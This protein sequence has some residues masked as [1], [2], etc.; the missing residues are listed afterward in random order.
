MN[1]TI[2]EVAKRARVS[3]ATVSRVLNN[4]G[5]VDENT[6]R[7][8]QEAARELRYVPNAVGRSLSTRRT[9]AIGLLLPDLYG[10]FFSEVIRGADQTAQQHRLHIVVSSS[11]NHPEEIN[12]ALQMMRGRVDGIIIMS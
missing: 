3:T 5:P 4:S 11:H 1:T 7:E 8:V 2:R 9:D 6:R 12:G 10:E